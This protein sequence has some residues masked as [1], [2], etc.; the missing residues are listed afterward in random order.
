MDI[1]IPWINHDRVADVWFQA[2]DSLP[3]PALKRAA[4]RVKS[5]PDR[6]LARSTTTLAA[7]YQ[8]RWQDQEQGPIDPSESS[9]KSLDSDFR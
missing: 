7:I 4:S 2:R 1:S 5:T 6:R 9:V 8:S 3:R